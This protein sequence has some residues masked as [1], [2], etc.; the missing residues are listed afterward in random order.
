[1]CIRDRLWTAMG[2]GESKDDKGH[3]TEKE[4]QTV[5]SFSAKKRKSYRPRETSTMQNSQPASDMS[6]WKIWN[7]LDCRD[8]NQKLQLGTFFHSIQQ[9]P[10]VKEDNWFR[11]SKQPEE[12]IETLHNINASLSNTRVDVRGYTLPA[13]FGLEHV[14]LLKQS[15]EDGCALELQTVKQIMKDVMPV[16]KARGNVIRLKP[17]AEGERMVVVG[18]LHG[19][20]ADLLRI[21][22]EQGTPSKTNRFVF[23]GDFVDRGH[24][25]MEVIAL[26]FAY[27]TCLPDSVTLLRG[28]HED[29]LTIQQYGFQTE[30]LAY[31][32]ERSHSSSSYSKLAWKQNGPKVLAKICRA[33]AWLPVVAILK[34]HFCVVHGGIPRAAGCANPDEHTEYACSLEAIEALPRGVLESTQAFRE[35]KFSLAQGVSAEMEKAVMKIDSSLVELLK[36]GAKWHRAYSRFSSLK[37]FNST[38][39][40]FLRKSATEMNQVAQALQEA[41]ETE[42]AATVRGAAHDFTKFAEIELIND[43]LWSDPFDHDFTTTCGKLEEGQMRGFEPNDSRGLGVVFSNDMAVDWINSPAINAPN[44]IRAHQQCPF[45]Y[46][47]VGPPSRILTIFSHSNYS[48]S[49]SAGGVFIFSLD[50]DMEVSTWEID[51]D[52]LEGFKTHNRERV[53]HV[54][55]RNKKILIG[56][57]KQRTSTSKYV[58]K[59]EWADLLTAALE[60]SLP[61]ESLQPILAPDSKWTKDGI[62]FLDWLEKFEV[63]LGGKHGGNAVSCLYKHASVVSRLFVYFDKSGRGML[64]PSEWAQGCEWF[65]AQLPEGERL[66][67]VE[68]LFTVLDHDASGEIDLNEFMEAFRITCTHD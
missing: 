34:D 32:G 7:E 39:P 3:E 61:W 11:G 35:L 15:V 49:G 54:I 8:E 51:N 57:F 4:V 52:G 30:V 50:H 20:L 45:G 59:H 16:L 47:Y 26:L 27:Q 2:C 22:E 67:D 42:K 25:G 56:A 55:A 53:V 38:E 36:S 10:L 58:D 12:E 23:D 37:Q 5:S 14:Q 1:M 62:D 19:S 24:C 43:L 9:L 31:P 63:K 13:D 17:L 64:T 60:L 41:G 6:E 18:D 46:C 66:E 68:E 28:N 21:F 29:S 33:F 48:N 40:G 65:N 44:L